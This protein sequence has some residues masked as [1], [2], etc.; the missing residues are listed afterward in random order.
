MSR[1]AT[2]AEAVWTWPERTEI[3]GEP[4]QPTDRKTRIAAAVWS[5]SEREATFF[6]ETA[7]ERYSRQPSTSR[8]YPRPR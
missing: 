5:Y 6:S 8:S 7:H 4:A 1:V 2:I 3:S